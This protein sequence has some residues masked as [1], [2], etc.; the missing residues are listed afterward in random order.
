MNKYLLCF[1]SILT[2]S[3]QANAGDF[4]DGVNER[5]N[6]LSTADKTLA[7]VGVGAAGASMG[8]SA[9]EM[10][11]EFAEMR[12]AIKAAGAG[13]TLKSIAATREAQFLRLMQGWIWINSSITSAAARASIL[14]RYASIFKMSGAM[15]IGHYIGVAACEAGYQDNQIAGNRCEELGSKIADHLLAITHPE[16]SAASI[17][18]SG[19]SASR[20]DKTNVPSQ[21]KI[22]ETT[23][24]STSLNRLASN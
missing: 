11:K 4:V 23:R 20:F 6:E 19:T 21:K 18:S 9:A 1:V 12:K 5:F 7:T 16:S 10:A 8:Y 2:I 13:N 3:F 14:S 17:M 24:K 15:L 22:Q